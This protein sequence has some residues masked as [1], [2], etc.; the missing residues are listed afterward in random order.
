MTRFVDFCL[1]VSILCI[2][3]SLLFMAGGIGYKSIDI[4]MAGLS[5]LLVS[6]ISATVLIIIKRF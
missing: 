1:M 6:T 4:F 5:Y 3:H 2:L